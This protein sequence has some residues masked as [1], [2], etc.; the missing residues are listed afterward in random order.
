MEYNKKASD[1][2]IGFTILRGSVFI[3]TYT[4][5][6]IVCPKYTS[7]KAPSPYF[8]LTLYFLHIIGFSFIN[9]SSSSSISIYF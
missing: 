5:F 8:F 3:A 9:L 2:N 1:S 4:L 6:D 7:P